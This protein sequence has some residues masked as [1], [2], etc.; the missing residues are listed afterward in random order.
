MTGFILSKSIMKL[1]IFLF[2]LMAVI[3][4]SPQDF[5]RGYGG[6]NGY[7]NG[8]NGYGGKLPR[9]TGENERLNVPSWSFSGG[10]L[11]VPRANFGNRNFGRF[12]S[13]G[14]KEGKHLQVPSH[15]KGIKNEGR[16]VGVPAFNNGGRCLSYMGYG[17]KSSKIGGQIE[18][19]KSARPG[20]F[21]GQ[22]GIGQKF[23]G[24]NQGF[25]GGQ[26]RYGNTGHTGFNNEGVY[27]VK[28]SQGVGQNKGLKGG[29]SG[30][31]N[32]GR[33]GTIYGVPGSNVAVQN[34]QFNNG[35]PGGFGVQRGYV[36]TSP[37][38]IGQNEA[39]TEINNSGGLSEH[40]V[41][42]CVWCS[43]RSPFRTG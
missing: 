21:G 11:G 27:G 6:R 29:H 39:L 19:F 28:G 30:F 18:R 15:N 40:P 33:F 34:E 32:G 22:I 36:R 35:R 12:E 13:Q 4:A 10:V 7:Q 14:A 3:L 42:R 24:Q 41:F 26:I 38:V 17:E 9:I 31:N 8:Q 25:N 1:L 2:A 23:S 43:R 5:G 37:Q 16:N 20:R